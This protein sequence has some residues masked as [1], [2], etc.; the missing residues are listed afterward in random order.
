MCVCFYCSRNRGYGAAAGFKVGDEKPIYD[1]T[2]NP[3][4]NVERC[5]R[6]HISYR[7]AN[8]INSLLTVG[9]EAHALRNTIDDTVV[10]F[11]HR[12]SPKKK[13]DESR[14]AGRRARRRT[15]GLAH[16]SL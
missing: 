5:Q 7:W 10:V 13:K 11:V 16:Q 3:S 8:T 1:G 14:S 6:I 12:A 15:N 2:K 4:A 9:S